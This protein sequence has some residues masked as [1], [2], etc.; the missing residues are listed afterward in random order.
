MRILAAIALAFF[1]S[2]VDAASCRKELVA[3]NVY[4]ICDVNVEKSDLRLFLR[5]EGGRVY[6]HFNRINDALAEDGMR[7]GFAMNAGMYHEDRRPVG[8]YVENGI[9]AQ[10]VIT[11]AGP[12]NFGLLPNG[13]FC[14]AGN[15]AVVMETRAFVKAAP[16]CT[17]A[18]Q[19]GPMLVIDGE[20]HPRFLRDSTSEF[21]RNGVGIADSGLIATFV[22]SDN[23]VNFHE[24]GLFFRDHLEMEN[25]LYLDGNISRLRAP[26]LFKEGAG[27]TPL[28]PIIGVVEP[29]E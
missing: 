29:L 21:I 12:G 4:T 22:I 16:D 19:S 6:G 20:L 18:T 1:A 11:S 24:F 15:R 10:R 28:G 5:D 26:D 27:F 17:Y 7:L 8:H 3:E 23:P 2:Q 13:V 25:A 14:L 9:E